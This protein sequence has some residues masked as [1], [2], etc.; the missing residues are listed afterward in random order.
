M[1]RNADRPGTAHEAMRGLADWLDEADRLIDTLAKA[2]MLPRANSGDGVQRD[3]R[4][5]ADWFEAH[6][7]TDAEAWKHVVAAVAA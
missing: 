1:S 4:A 3:L 7:A 6:P 5:L 2:K